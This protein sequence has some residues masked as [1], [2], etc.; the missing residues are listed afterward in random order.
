M[1]TTDT[2]W[3]KT[4]DFYK[5]LKNQIKKDKSF[6]LALYTSLMRA[7]NRGKSELHHDLYH[8]IDRV[9]AGGW[10]A[11]FTRSIP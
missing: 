10:L 8:A 6:C 3:P 11:N 5:E 9:F 2:R 7:Q 1:N 4:T